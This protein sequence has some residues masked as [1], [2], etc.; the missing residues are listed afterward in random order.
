MPSLQGRSVSPKPL[1]I[2]E[3]DKGCQAL[4]FAN[5]REAVSAAAALRQDSLFIVFLASAAA[6]YI[7]GETIE[8]NGGIWMD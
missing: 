1:P 6:R 8:V 5:V 4:P 3:N 7:T 2:P